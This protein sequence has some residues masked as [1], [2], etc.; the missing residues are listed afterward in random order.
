MTPA[1]V[2]FVAACGRGS[3]SAQAKLPLKAGAGKA[4][5]CSPG[6]TAMVVAA[7]LVAALVGLVLAAGATAPPVVLTSWVA[8]VLVSYN[9][10]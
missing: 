9:N 8:L 3:L 6:I 7:T 4:V 2:R 5:N 1:S 10:G